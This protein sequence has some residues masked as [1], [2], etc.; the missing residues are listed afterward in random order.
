MKHYRDEWIQE[1][2]MENGWTDLFCERSGNYW[3]FPPGAVMPEPV[4]LKVLRLIKEQKGL[5]LE[6]RVLLLVVSLASIG[7]V[8]STFLSHCPMPLVLAFALGAIAIPLLDDE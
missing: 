4:P 8:V 7:A 1:W 2:C 3:A 6:E 5:C